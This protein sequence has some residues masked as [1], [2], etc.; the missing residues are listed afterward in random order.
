MTKLMRNDSFYFCLG[1][2]VHESNSDG[3]IFPY[4]NEHAP[5]AGVKE[6]RGIHFG[7]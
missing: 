2:C 6:Y 1:M 5:K 7:T 4:G 3:K